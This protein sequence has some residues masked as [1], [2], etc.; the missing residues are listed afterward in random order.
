MKAAIIAGCVV[1]SVQCA[2]PGA[3]A[4]PYHGIDLDPAKAEGLLPRSFLPRST[5]SRTLLERLL[6]P[7]V[8]SGQVQLYFGTTAGSPEYARTSK[9]CALGASLER[10]LD[11]LPDIP[12]VAEFVPGYE[13]SP[14]YGVGV[15]K[16]T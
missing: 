15:P 13:A 16:N 2:A 10:R 7:E 11:A 14:W 9:L 3:Y 5:Y 12:A 6:P 4:Q 1:L 8:L